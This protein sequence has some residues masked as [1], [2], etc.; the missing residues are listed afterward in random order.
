MCSLPLSPRL[1]P[2]FDTCVATNARMLLVS[3]NCSS[4]CP[5]LDVPRVS[6]VLSTRAFL[7]ASKKQSTQKGPR[8]EPC[9]ILARGGR[10]S[11]RLAVPKSSD[12]IARSPDGRYI[13]TGTSLAKGALGPGPRTRPSGR[14]GA[15]P[16]RFFLPW[17]VARQMSHFH[18][19]K[20]IVRT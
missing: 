7:R 9:N 6:P 20:L 2:N 1:L 12:R 13:V 15:H 4:N 19:L 14:A 8:G 3:G 16:A 17:P 10:P 11:I 5:K 18:L